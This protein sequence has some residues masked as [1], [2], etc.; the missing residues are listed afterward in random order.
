MKTAALPSLLPTT[1]PATPS[2]EGKVQG[3]LS[4]AE[5]PACLFLKF[6]RRIFAAEDL[7]FSHALP[8]D[9]TL[10]S[11]VFK[12]FHL[13]VRGAAGR[14]GSRLA[15]CF[16]TLL[17]AVKGQVRFDSRDFCFATFRSYTLIL[18]YYGKN[19][20]KNEK[21]ISVPPIPHIILALGTTPLSLLVIFS[22]HIAFV[23][24]AD[25]FPSLSF[26]GEDRDGDR[27]ASLWVWRSPPPLGSRVEVWPLTWGP[28]GPMYH[29]LPKDILPCPAVPRLMRF[30]RDIGNRKRISFLS[31]LL[32]ET[33]I[34]FHGKTGDRDSRRRPSRTSVL[35]SRAESRLGRAGERC[36]VGERKVPTDC[37]GFYPF[38][39]NDIVPCFSRISLF[40]SSSSRRK[41]KGCYPKIC[42]LQACVAHPLQLGQLLFIR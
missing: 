25:L 1:E 41:F 37:Y 3:H 23:I 21:S 9:D 29:A 34:L 32:L 15:L 42:M 19:S 18:L 14:G 10:G 11:F 27:R 35:S 38:F 6:L 13:A 40:I 30:F 24:S 8:A 22:R 20:N 26:H 36:E 39:T 33:R 28:Q 5:G 2:A 12:H 17:L 16:F 31:F 7:L 4:C